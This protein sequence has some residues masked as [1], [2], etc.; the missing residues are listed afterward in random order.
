MGSPH[1]FLV[2]TLLPAVLLAGCGGEIVHGPA[3]PPDEFGTQ[4]TAWFGCPAMQGMYA[5]PPEAG[6]YSDGIATNEQPWAGGMPAPIGRGKMQVWIIEEGQRLTVLSRDRPADGNT[7]PG[8]RRV[9]GYSE[10]YGLACRSD[11]RDADDEEIGNGHEFGCEGLRRG[12]RL[13]RMDDGA[14]AVGIRTVAYGCRESVI[15]WG[16]KSVGDMKAPDR[17]YWR[18]SKLRRIGDGAPPATP[19]GP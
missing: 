15:T 19:A 3:S 18:W 12:F 6:D 2:G 1:R 16:D 10:H 11:M 7:D 13:A 14:L 9:W 4:E 5:W 17:V 8:L